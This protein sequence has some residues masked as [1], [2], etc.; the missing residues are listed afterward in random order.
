[1]MHAVRDAFEEA[2]ADWNTRVVI[3]ESANPRFFSAGWDIKA[4]APDPDSLPPAVPQYGSYM[5][6]EVFRA[7][8]QCGAPV[9]AKVS[10]IAVGAGFLY[11]CLADFV[12]AADTAQFGQFEIKVGAVGGAGIVRRMMS[13][14]AMRYLTWTAALVG[15]SELVALGAGIRVVPAAS[16]DSEVQKIAQLLASRDPRV[17]RHTKTAMNQ[18]EPLGAL[19][20][21]TFE[22]MHSSI[23]SQGPPRKTSATAS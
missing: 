15:V 7:I 22:Q 16:L 20:A 11:A 19:E 4:P 17:T 13:E 9:I 10:G 3:F 5:G 14:Q 18:V 6:R 1:M 8:Y 12:V 21:Y 23:I 2:S